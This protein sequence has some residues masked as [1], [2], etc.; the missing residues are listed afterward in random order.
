MLLVVI[1]GEHTC[2]AVA[3]VLELE[4][5]LA[6]EVGAADADPLLVDDITQAEFFDIT[7]IL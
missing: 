5:W 1:D 2:P 6:P 3:V 7:R 4:A